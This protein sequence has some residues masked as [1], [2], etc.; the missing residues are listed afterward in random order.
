[1]DVAEGGNP[2]A[3]PGALSLN[4]ELLGKSVHLTAI[5]SLLHAS[6]LSS[7]GIRREKRKCT[8]SLR[9]EP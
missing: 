2:R 9:G 3:P 6:S 5:H 8:Y 1:M 4:C 7:K